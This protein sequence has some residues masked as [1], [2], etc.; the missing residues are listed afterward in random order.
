MS[1]AGPPGPRS[2]ASAE[3]RRH[4]RARRV[5]TAGLPSPKERSERGR[6][7]GMTVPVVPVPTVLGPRA[8]FRT[9]Q[10]PGRLGHVYP[11]QSSL[12]R[13][14]S[15]RY[16][17]GSS[18]RPTTRRRSAR[19]L[20][21]CFRVAQLFDNLS[22]VFGQTEMLLALTNSLVVVVDRDGLRRPHLHVGRIRLREAPI[23]RPQ[24]VVA[25]VVATMMVPTQLAIIPLY[26]MMAH[27]S[28]M[29]EQCARP[30]RPGGGQRVRRVLHAPVSRHRTSHRTA[31][32]GPRQSVVPR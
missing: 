25:L 1:I 32:G 18:R 26:I 4:D 23:P 6:R 13:S 30:D 12:R 16:T 20:R 24:R 17:G 3:A 2:G 8:Q 10:P 11:S 21:P 7:G 15:S 19:C 28:W 27:S 9:E 22:K 29:G 31:R 5:E 14:Q